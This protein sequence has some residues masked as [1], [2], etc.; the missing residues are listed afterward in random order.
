[1]SSQ[2]VILVL[3]ATGKVGGETV[4]QLKSAGDNRVLAAVRSP[5][6]AKHFHAQGIETVVL[7]LDQPETL[8]VG[9]EGVN[10]AL[11]L[12]GYSVDMMRQSKRFVDAAKQAGVQHIV[13][14]GA[15]GAATNEVAHWGWHQF[16]EAYIEQQGFSYTHLR[17][18]AFMQNVTGPGYR[19]LE[20][21]V[22]RHH[23]GNARWSWIDCQDLALV[24]AHTLQEPEKYAGQIIP[25]GYDAKT[26]NEVAELL[27]EVVGQP[28][29]AEARP[30]E[31][32]LEN[33]LAAG[34]D[35]AYMTCIYTQ[36]KLNSS[37]AIPNADATFDNFE[38]ITGQKP[39]TWQE[40]AQ[41]HKNE[42]AY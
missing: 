19:W 24:A 22:I 20:G 37:G 33:A 16:V 13:H 18:E 12:S 38:A 4:R 21:N 23:V 40:F 7:D 2:P 28:F 8:K 11:L 9:L 29:Y 26:F 17:P 32:F 35:P 25:L 42:L 34:A 14:I 41:Q 15:S 5:E 36:F 6:K 1:M 31:E 39:I 30:P 10:R 3:G 27:T